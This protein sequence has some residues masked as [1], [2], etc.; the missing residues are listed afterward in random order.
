MALTVRPS[1]G[2][3]PESKDTFKATFFQSYSVVLNAQSSADKTHGALSLQLSPDESR[4]DVGGLYT[5]TQF[6]VDLKK[7]RPVSTQPV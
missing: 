5:R 7:S 4:G 6:R 1:G 2:R 3:G